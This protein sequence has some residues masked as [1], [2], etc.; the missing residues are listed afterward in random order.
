MVAYTNTE[1]SYAKIKC[2]W[3]DWHKLYCTLHIRNGISVDN[4]PKG[5][6]LSLSSYLEKLMWA[7]MKK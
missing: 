6:N 1:C 7:V 5:P 2:D 4:S 3:K